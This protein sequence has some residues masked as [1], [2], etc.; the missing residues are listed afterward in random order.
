M[1]TLSLIN[2]GLH[3]ITQQVLQNILKHKRL[4]H[5]YIFYG[6]GQHK[7]E[8]AIEFAK[9]VNCEHNQLDACSSCTTCKTIENGNHPDVL[10]IQPQGNHIKIDTLRKL[11]NKFHYQSPTGV[12][13]FVIIEQAE[14]MRVEAA[15][16]LLKFLEE[17]PS[18]MVAILITDQVQ[19]I[20]PTIQSRCQKIRFFQHSL[21]QQV[22]SHQQLGDPD[23]LSSIRAQLNEELSLTAE[24]FEQLINQAILLADQLLTDSIDEAFI[25][26]LNWCHSPQHE[27]TTHLL[28]VLLF[29]LR[30][31]LYFQATE[32]HQYFSS[33]QSNLAQQASKQSKQLIQLA[34]ENVM[35][36]R[37][38]L[39]KSPYKPQDILEQMILAIHHRT[40]S[41]ENGWQLIMI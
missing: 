27:N 35:I 12:T 1:N 22:E 32:T 36:A 5:A 18:P 37:R 23:H 21:Q 24:E 15:N 13:R 3:P 4:A 6:K 26:V 10:S 11:Q 40:L 7:K 20:L 14:K 2:I 39:T 31:I 41:Q 33:W 16:S 9:A 34:I 38:L 28:D 8:A 19:S 17:P 29:W 25:T 30:E